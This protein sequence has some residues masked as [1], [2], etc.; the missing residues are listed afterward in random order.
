MRGMA[1]SAGVPRARS[2]GRAHPRGD[3]HSSLDLIPLTEVIWSIFRIAVAAA[4]GG[5]EPN[6]RAR[7]EYSRRLAGEIHD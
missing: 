2:F 3:L 6:D 7:L 5:L 1:R 4:A